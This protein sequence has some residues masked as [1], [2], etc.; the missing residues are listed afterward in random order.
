MKVVYVHASK[1][2]NGA[3]VADEFRSRMANHDIAVETHHVDEVE[4]EAIA[5]AD[6]GFTTAP[7]RR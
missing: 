6:V 4:P 7:F 5:P 1:Y 3:R 2:G